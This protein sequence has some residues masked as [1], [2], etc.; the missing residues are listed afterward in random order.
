[1]FAHKLKFHL[2]RNPMTDSVEFFIKSPNEQGVA[3]M[4]P[5]Q[6]RQI[7]KEDR[8]SGAAYF[9]P[10]PSLS[11]EMTDC[12]QLM[13]ELWHCGVRP[14]EGS[15]SAGSLAATQKHLDDMRHLVFKTK[16]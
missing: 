12:Q 16:P 10:A 5:V 1:M 8:E 4:E 11:V 3:V 7:T 9:G 15:G 2:R 13:D 14:T 6:F